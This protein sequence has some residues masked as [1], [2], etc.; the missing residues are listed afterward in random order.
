[1]VGSSGSCGLIAEV[2]TAARLL[3]DIEKSPLG[4]AASTS[5]LP[6]R[7]PFYCT[8]AAER[9]NTQCRQ[10]EHLNSSQRHPVE[11]CPLENKNP[12]WVVNRETREAGLT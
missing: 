1:M 9:Y 5:S 4:S 11:M 7:K 3:E 12:P 6:P 8:R 2:A 10:H